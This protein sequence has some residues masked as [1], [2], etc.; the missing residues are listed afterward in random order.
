[1]LIAINHLKWT[2]FVCPLKMICFN[3]EMGSSKFELNK[4]DIDEA[5]QVRFIETE[6]NLF[7]PLWRYK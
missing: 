6:K 7:L 2:G 3:G 4:Q 1:M 5:A